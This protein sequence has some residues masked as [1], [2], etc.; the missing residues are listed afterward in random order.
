M[1]LTNIGYDFF[2]EESDMED[3]FN[4]ALNTIMQKYQ[5]EPYVIEKPMTQ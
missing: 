2:Q 1:K 4:Q 5:N 3:E